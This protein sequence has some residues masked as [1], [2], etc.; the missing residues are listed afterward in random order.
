M[1]TLHFVLTIYLYCR[2]FRRMVEVLHMNLLSNSYNQCEN[3]ALLVM[4]PHRHYLNAL[5]GDMQGERDF[6]RISR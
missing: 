2:E 5:R 4:N 3:L 1:L 6:E